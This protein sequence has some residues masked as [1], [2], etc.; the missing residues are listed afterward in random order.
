MG[1]YIGKQILREIE[2]KQRELERQMNHPLGFIIGSFHMRSLENEAVLHSFKIEY[3]DKFKHGSTQYDTH[4][5]GRN[6]KEGIKAL[7]RAFT[8]G[9]NHFK[10]DK[11]ETFNDS[12]IQGIAGRIGHNTFNS[13]EA[14][15]RKKS[16]SI[17]GASW[18]PPYPD[19]IPDQLASFFYDICEILKDDSVGA[20]VEA[21]AF[22][23][24]NL[25]RIHPFIDC[26]GRTCRTVQNVILRSKNLP[27][28]VIYSGERFDYYGHLQRGIEGLQSRPTSLD[29]SKISRGERD[30]YDY[31]GS[32]VSASL[33]RLLD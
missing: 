24:L 13:N 11:P 14:P 9:S 5:S 29:Y 10:R 15:Y 19:K 12:L 4:A 7:E 25:D 17:A 8:Y 33:D 18:K 32:M 1:K 21:A 27:P 22:A 16:V 3:P 23:H 26:N 20:T 6:K 30:F 28:P 31:I 2:D